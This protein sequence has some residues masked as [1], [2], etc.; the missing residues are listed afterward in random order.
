MCSDKSSKISSSIGCGIYRDDCS[1]PSGANRR[2]AL[3]AALT[4][5]NWRWLWLRCAQC[6]STAVHDCRVRLRYNHERCSHRHIRASRIRA[7]NISSRVARAI[8]CRR[9][10]TLP[11]RLFLV[12]LPPLAITADGHRRFSAL[13][14]PARR[15]RLREHVARDLALPLALGRPLVHQ[16][17]DTHAKRVLL[18][19][20]LA[21]EQAKR[22]VRHEPRRAERH[23]RVARRGRRRE[24]VLLDRPP[25]VVVPVSRGRRVT[26]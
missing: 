19:G 4:P 26:H 16:R 12:T 25:L 1:I 2:C 21:D 20:P 10:M 13:H 22:H 5:C 9:H 23:A 17:G 8:L 14:R 24:Q 11:L 7:L 18:C 15:R 3:S 6:E